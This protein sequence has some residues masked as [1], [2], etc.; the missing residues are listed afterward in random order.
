M[1]GL[2]RLALLGSLGARV[3]CGVT[4]RVHVRI[5]AHLKFHLMLTF[6]SSFRVSFEASLKAYLGAYLKLLFED[7]IEPK[8]LK[9]Y[10]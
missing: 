9:L 8:Q 1:G 5:H 3:H 2:A 10:F 6:K 4:I 7:Q